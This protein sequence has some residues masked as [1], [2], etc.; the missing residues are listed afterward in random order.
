MVGTLIT[1][2]GW[3]TGKLLDK[4]FDELYSSVKESKS[5]N[6]KFYTAVDIVS[7]DLQTQYP[8]VLDG[9]IKYFFKSE[10]V[11]NELFK[12]L[13]KSSKLNKKKIAQ[14]FDTNT[15][16]K[17]FILKFVSALKIELLKD[18]LFDE[19][20]SNN[21]LYFIFQ[22][23]E[24]NIKLIAKNT[25]IS[26]KELREIKEIVIKKFDDNFNF[27]EFK[28]LYTKNALNSLSQ[29]NFLGLG[30]DS[31][32]K[33]H[34]KNLQD[35]FIRPLCQPL[36]K[37]SKINVLED[38]DEDD[39]DDAIDYSRI[40]SYHNKIVIL[41]NPGAGKSVLVR[42]LMC[43]ILSNNRK[44]FLEPGICNLVPFRIELRKY[45][46]YKKENKGSILKYLS[47]SLE[48]DYQIN[49]ITESTINEIF[50]HFNCIIFF[51]GLDEIFNIIDKIEAKTDIENFQNKY[52]C[53]KS[54]TTSRIIGYEETSLNESFQELLIRKF[55]DDQIEEYV[56][57]WYEKEEDNDH[58]RGQEVSGFL[59]KRHEIDR[60][61]ITNPLL[62][63]LIVIIY[64]N[65]LKIPESKLEIYQSCTKT[66][67]DKWEALKNLKF[68]L[69]PEVLKSKDKL[70]A[71]LAYWQ[72]E[73]LSGD[74]PQITYELAKNTVAISLERL[75]IA[76]NFNSESIA[77]EF[78]NYASK[79]SIYFE[80]N[81]THKTFL[82]YYTAYWIYSNVEKAHDIKKRDEIITKYIGNPFWNIVLE[83]LFNLIDKDLGTNSVIDSIVT[84]Q[85]KTSS[86]SIP[87]LL[88]VCLNIK[89]ISK[90][91]IAYIISSAIETTLNNYSKNKDPHIF[92]AV[93][94]F[95]FRNVKSKNLLKEK[96]KEL[97]IA[98][99]EDEINQLKL[100]T[101][102]AELNL[103]Y[104]VLGNESFE[105]TA[106]ETYQNLL[107]KDDYLYMVNMYAFTSGETFLEDFLL[108]LEI[109]D[110]DKVFTG[111]D[112]RYQELRFGELFISMIYRLME[113]EESIISDYI[114]RYDKAGLNFD[115]MIKF[116]AANEQNFHFNKRHLEKLITTI[117]FVEN[118]AVKKI[119]FL[120]LISFNS[121]RYINRVKSTKLLLDNFKY[122]TLL[123]CLIDTKLSFSE[124]VDEILLL[125]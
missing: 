106:I 74:T 54:I 16:P 81:F 55:N 47:Y 70:L 110:Q 36:G 46:A 4:G 90:N 39:V 20:F 124:K 57:K 101:L 15:L 24:K 7:K 66:L 64:R 120:I 83:L 32:K 71:D 52:A 13:F 40:I 14:S 94:S 97:E 5:I 34:R 31:S 108:F 111:Y 107:S 8:D 109:F 1:V 123:T 2:G 10:K 87:F 117:S 105:L 102:Y 35:I 61:L 69:D 125:V 22:G 80:D 88:S 114:V 17:D 38:F 89:N 112:S 65:A 18:K 60:E 48:T 68:D 113:K 98:F 96:F 77:E 27:D 78:M 86:K 30:L 56:T 84:D 67:V 25:T 51:D 28:D 37:S 33:I 95:Y 82:E 91:S 121:V 99:K 50:V 122:K 29:I 72:Y 11:F 93:E 92:P 73:K 62:L 53:L 23:I 76:D 43:D 12:L 100:Y 63:S 21:E 115:K 104:R 3:L 45:I 42:S 19:I 26:A 59:Y 118:L 58:I 6:K 119:L 79:R 9:N 103:S 75:E 44:A 85:I 116:L 49:N 41:G